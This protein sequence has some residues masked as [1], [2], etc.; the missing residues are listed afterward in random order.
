M[1]DDVNSNNARNL[2]HSPQ[3]GEFNA[4]FSADSPVRTGKINIR[5]SE[6][7]S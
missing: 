2:S 6:G 4:N 5:S 7:N 1:S 3:K